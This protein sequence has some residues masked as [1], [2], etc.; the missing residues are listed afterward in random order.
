MSWPKRIVLLRH[1]ESEGNIR[2]SDDISFEDKA[3]HA[4]ALTEKGRE[5]ARTAGMRLRGG[6]PE[7]DSYFCS[8]FQRTQETLSLAYPS[9]IPV[10]D[11]RLNE[12]WRGIWH[13]MSRE[14]VLELYPEESRIREREGE[15]HYRPPGGQSC[16]DVELMIYSFLLSLRADY[17]GKNVLI[18]AHGNWMLLFWRIV[19]NRS[20]IAFESRYKGDKYKNCAIA[21]YDGTSAGITLIREGVLP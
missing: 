10:I 1:G 8:T 16:Q 6:W 13:T 3:N 5:Q 7:F 18:S 20:P 2:S 9:A 12:L 21:E 14:K 11:S 15:Y 19:C 4:F 17:A